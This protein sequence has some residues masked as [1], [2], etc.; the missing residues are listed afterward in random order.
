MAIKAKVGTALGGAEG[1]MKETLAFIEETWRKVMPGSPFDY[2]F[3]DDQFAN[4]Y[5]N[6]QAFATM[7]T[8]FTALAIVIAAMGLFALS[9]YTTE[10]R[11][12]EIGIRKVMGASNSSIL[13]KL[14]GEFVQLVLIAFVLAAAIAWF[15]MNQW[16][17]DFQYSIRIGP[18]IFLVAGG[19]SILIAILTISY[20]SLRAM[21]AN[22]VESLRSE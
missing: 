17:L 11:R 5:R 6:E 16:L 15:V 18:G 10:Q 8:H 1:G 12:Q 4:L 14:T 2:A 19:A 9:A 22:P 20:Q 3:L 13:I 21:M 7:F